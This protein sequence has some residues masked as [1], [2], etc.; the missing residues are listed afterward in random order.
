VSK[1]LTGNLTGL[2]LRKGK[3]RRREG[4]KDG[5]HENGVKAG[6][7]QQFRKEF[8]FESFFPQ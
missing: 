2:V 3:N 7:E 6:R 5:T 1:I 4:S 8:N